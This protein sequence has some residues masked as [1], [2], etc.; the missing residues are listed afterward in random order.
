MPRTQSPRTAI[1]GGTGSIGIATA[2]RVLQKGMPVVILSRRLPTQALPESIG[3]ESLDV[4]DAS[5]VRE[6]LRKHRIDRVVHL[7]ALLQFACEQDPVQ[8]V[9]INVDGTLN[10]LEACRALEVSRVVFA[11]SIAV[12]GERSDLM[13]ESDP[14]PAGI[15]LYGQTKRMGEILGQRYHALH[16]LEFVAL[17]YSGVFGPGAATSAGM[18][19]V[20]QRILD[21]A[22]GKDV[23]IEGAS[24]A[25][26]VN[27]THVDDAAQA[28]CTALLSNQYA[29][30]IYN[31]AGPPENYVSL[32]E[33]H[34]LVRELRPGTGRALWSGQARSA[35][36]VDIARIGRELGWQPSVS[37]KDGL[38]DV[39]ERTQKA[40]RAAA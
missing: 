8:A 33:L 31:V 20:R 9:R 22:A 7:A 18:A 3:W 36:Q 16:G 21:C 13:R 23:V 5:A 27:L 19:L 28:T 30:A 37:L 26:R 39:L 10:V 17:R 1:I 35:G 15:G 12:Y 29:S 2:M 34:E 38:R 14:A 32:R 24:G 40:A 25:E 11:S 6:A 4:T